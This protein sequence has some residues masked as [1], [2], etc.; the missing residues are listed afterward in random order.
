MSVDWHANT[1]SEMIMLKLDNPL[2]IDAR[3]L[4][5]KGRLESAVEEHTAL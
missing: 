5:L 3:F 1:R 2:A 4:D